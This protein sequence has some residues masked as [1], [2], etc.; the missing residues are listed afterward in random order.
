VEAA[1]KSGLHDLVI[2]FPDGYATDI[3]EAGARLSGGMRQRLSIARAL[4]GDPPVLLLD[5]PS[6]NLDREGEMELMETLDVLAKDHT[7]MV[8]SHAPG[9]LSRCRQVLVMQKGR[10]VRSGRPL[11]VLPHLLG[12]NTAPPIYQRQA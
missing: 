8:I 10:I 7:I 1:K 12:T 3:G 5:E 6:S 11:D 4:L 2:D 9:V